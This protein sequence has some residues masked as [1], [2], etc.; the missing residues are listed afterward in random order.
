MDFFFVRFIAHD[1]RL[2]ILHSKTN[3]LPEDT[4]FPLYRC[5]TQSRKCQSIGDVVS[6]DFYC[7]KHSKAQTTWAI[8]CIC[9]LKAFSWLKFLYLRSNFTTFAPYF[10]ND[11]SS[12]SLAW[13]RTGANPLPRQLF[14][15]LLLH[16]C[17]IIPNPLTMRYHISLLALALFQAVVGDGDNP[18]PRQNRRASCQITKGKALYLYVNPRLRDSAMSCGQVAYRSMIREI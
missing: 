15:Y 13:R 8:F 17:A 3:T 6:L 14:L 11:N 12:S 16:M 10:P 7:F 9:Y 5:A 1:R 2:T 4:H 18:K